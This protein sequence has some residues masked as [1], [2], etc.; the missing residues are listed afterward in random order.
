MRAINIFNK[1]N[2]QYFILMSLF[3]LGVFVEFAS[4]IYLL[5][6]HLPI[7]INVFLVAH[8]A[9]SVLISLSIPYITESLYIN[10]QLFYFLFSLAI[11]AFIP[12]IGVFV[13]I[14]IYSSKKNGAI[15]QHK[16]KVNATM[17]RINISNLS[18]TQI[19]ANSAHVVSTNS[20]ASI[21]ASDGILAEERQKAVLDTI[22]LPD[23]EAIPLLRKALKDDE[24]DVR[25]LAYT[26]LKRKE[27]KVTSRLN[28]RLREVNE[29]NG[30]VH[31]SLHKAIVYDCWEMILLE[32][33]QGEALN[34]LF[35]LAIKHIKISL[36]HNNSDPVFNLLYAKILLKKGNLAQS[37]KIFMD[38]RMAGID[39]NI[40]LPYFAELAFLEKRFC[41]M[42]NLFWD[43][44]KDASSHK[45]RD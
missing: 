13:I 1:D 40:I 24:D 42:S 6:S 31:I 29:K 10:C 18:L 8:I 22:K 39:R 19:N 25:L 16:A 15:N 4:I 23:K 27:N 37:R 7:N 32:L 38:V 45:N 44:G 35:E 34:N 14:V 33:M 20:I 43:I 28:Y 11:Q 12:V 21:I 36:R 30:S 5:I 3:C 41:N 9:G 17:S 26:L 2:L